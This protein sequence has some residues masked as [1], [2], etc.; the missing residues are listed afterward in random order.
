MIGHG[1]GTSSG[2]NAVMRTWKNNSKRKKISEVANLHKVMIVKTYK[3]ERR[4]RE[5]EKY[6][7]F[8]NYC[9]M[10]NGSKCPAFRM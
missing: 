1:P 6:S 2:F 8:S 7:K 5:T 10:M 4:L 3:L 9:F